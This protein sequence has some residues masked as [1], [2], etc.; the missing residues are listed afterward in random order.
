M[1]TS[2]ERERT[3]VLFVDGDIKLLEKAKQRLQLRDDFDVESA[4]SVKEALK[5][6]KNKKTDAIIC[7]CDMPVTDGFAFLKALRDNGNSVPFIVFTVT[8]DKKKAIKAFSLGA[9]GFI[10]KYGDP[11]VVFSTLKRCIEKSL[12][13]NNQ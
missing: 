9:N 1:P 7:D 4:T 2:N 10:G 8:E 3:K 13:K 12:L 6:I 11:E 5:K